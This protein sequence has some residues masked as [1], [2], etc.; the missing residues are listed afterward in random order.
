MQDFRKKQGETLDYVI[1]WTAYLDGDSIVGSSWAAVPATGVVINSPAASFNAVSATVWVSSGTPGQK[2]VLEN[3][4]TTAAG[5]VVT[6]H[7]T[8]YIQEVSS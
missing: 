6:D 4:V 3:T 1:D 2:Y 5:R 8:V 7:I